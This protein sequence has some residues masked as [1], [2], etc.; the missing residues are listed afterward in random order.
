M[1][2]SES[3]ETISASIRQQLEIQA[4]QWTQVL[5]KPG[6]VPPEVL[7]TYLRFSRIRQWNE[8][9]KLIMVHWYLPED[10]WAL[11]HIELEQ[12]THKFGTDK[13]I[14]ALTMLRSEP[15][16]MLY[17]LES[18]CVARNPRELFGKIRS[19]TNYNKYRYHWILPR[20]PKRVTRKR[21]YKDQGFRRPD[22]TWVPDSDWSLTEEQNR[23]EEIR[24]LI[25]DHSLLNGGGLP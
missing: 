11:V 6:F 20:R 12:Y 22:H 18:S 2:F 17:L 1:K 14:V 21:G 5:R 23:I 19:T 10:L 25:V 24:E 7:G 4:Q 3:Y 16:M 9:L 13:A 8:Y 15:E